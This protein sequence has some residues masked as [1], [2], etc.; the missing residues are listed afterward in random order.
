MREVRFKNLEEAIAEIKRLEN[1]PKKTIGKWSYYQILNHCAEGIECSMDGYSAN[2]PWLIRKTI[3]QIIKHKLFLQGYMDHGAINPTAP[4]IREEGNEKIALERL[5]N[6]FERF[7]KHDKKLYPHPF[8]DELSKE[9]FQKLHA[10]HV[11]NHLCFV[12]I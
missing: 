8:F 1:I 11:A 10:Y 7:K 9:E 3:G 2:V 6:A 5:L 12:E 4:K